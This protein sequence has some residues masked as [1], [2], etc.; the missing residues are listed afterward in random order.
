MV[1]PIWFCREYIYIYM[2]IPPNATPQICS[3]YTASA[4]RECGV[5][6]F[7]G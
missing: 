5:G 1:I 7:G 2:G 6:A 3:I 4:L